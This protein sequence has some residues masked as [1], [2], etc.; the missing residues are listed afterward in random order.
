MQLSATATRW[1]AFA[2]LPGGVLL[3]LA[4]SIPVGF[5]L[6]NVSAT[7]VRSVAGPTN[8]LAVLRQWLTLGFAVLF[9]SAAVPAIA[10]AAH[11][12]WAGAVGAALYAVGAFFLAVEALFAVT[13][14]ATVLPWHWLL[15]PALLSF[16]AV[17]FGVG[18]FRS[19]ALP[20]GAGLLLA[21][22]QPTALFGV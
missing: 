14:A 17:L 10:K 8:D 15:V 9:A 1:L 2:S 13:S 12:G 6:P 18:V 7:D 16:G 4:W 3:I 19:G 11:V 5:L 22:I 20:R 21:F